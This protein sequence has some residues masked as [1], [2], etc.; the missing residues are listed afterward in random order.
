MWPG[1]FGVG[2]ELCEEEEERLDCGGGVGE[3]VV[4]RFGI[5]DYLAEMC[6]EGDGGGLGC[7]DGVFGG[8][9]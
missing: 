7:L 3:C 8:R 5:G 9:F 6:N 1:Q 4:M 2:V